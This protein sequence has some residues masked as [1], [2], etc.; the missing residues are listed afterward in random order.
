[1][2]PLTIKEQKILSK[3]IREAFDELDSNDFLFK[4]SAY[5]LASLSESLDLL[6]LRDEIINDLKTELL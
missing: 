5:E 4:D 3:L 2:H 1:M 6:E